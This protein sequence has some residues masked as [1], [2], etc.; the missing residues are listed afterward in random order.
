[1]ISIIGAG[2]SGNYLA[3]LLAKKGEKVNVYEEHKSIGKPIQCT[4]ILTDGITKVFDVNNEYVVNEIN[5]VRVFS[6]KENYLDFNIKKNFIVNRSLFDGYLAGEASGAGAKYFLGSKFNGCSINNG[7][8]IN[9]NNEIKDTKYLVGADGPF[10]A[11]AKSAGMYGRRRFII[12]P[13]AR[14]KL[15]IEEDTM[16]VYLGY[17]SF[18]WVVPE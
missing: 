10:S 3:Y 17:G 6:P 4:G 5:K 15:S 16:E 9:I 12:G 2:P 14:V 18:G 13:Q 1:M 11:V 8:R 7:I